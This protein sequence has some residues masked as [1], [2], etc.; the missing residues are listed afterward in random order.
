MIKSKDQKISFVPSS[1]SIKGYSESKIAKGERND[2]VVRAIASASDMEYDKAH[3]FVAK[4]FGRKPKKGT[5]FFASTM[6]GFEK[7][8]KKINRKSVKRIPRE[9]LKSGKSQM[10]V[11]TFLQEYNY[12][13]YI[14]AVTGHAFAVKDGVVLG[15]WSDAKRLRR[16]VE[17]AWKIGK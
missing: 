8:S 15:G 7:N 11:G 9:F 16:I 3:K 14:L 12:G 17:G 4:N 5:F 10:T 1:E 13:T 6:S 2:C